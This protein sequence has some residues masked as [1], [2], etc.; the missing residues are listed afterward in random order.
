MRVSR[1]RTLAPWRAGSL[2]L[3]VCLLLL[4]GALA[5]NVPHPPSA[6]Q[7][8]APRL[9]LPATTGDP[10]EGL[11]SPGMD[12]FQ[13]VS[14]RL[15]SPSCL[16][17]GG[18]HGWLAYDHADRAVWAA[19]EPNC[20]VVVSNGSLVDGIPVGA[21]PFGVA[22]DP[23][24]DLVFV[25]N[26]GSDNVSVI[27]D[28]TDQP[29]ASIGVGVAPAGIAYAGAIG[30]MFVANS[31][32]NNISII[33][34]ATMSVVG[35]VNVGMGPVGVA[36]DALDG[37]VYV[38]NN[39]SSSVSVIAE[40][41][42]TV[43]AT[44]PAGSTPRGVAWDSGD[45]RIFV[46]NQGSNNVT[47]INAAAGT[48]LAAVPAIPPAYGG[49]TLL[50]GMTYDN[51]SGAIWIGAGWAYAMEINASAPQ[52]V[53]F[54]AVDPS[55]M[56][57]DYDAHQVCG[58]D[59]GNVSLEC[60]QHASVQ[61]TQPLWFNETGLLPGTPW[62][63]VIHAYAGDYPVSGTGPSLA[64]ATMKSALSQYTFTIPPAGGYSA[65]PS[66]GNV[67]VTSPPTT[68]VVTFGPGPPLYG[69]TFASQGLP[70]GDAWSVDLDG[71]LQISTRSTLTFAEPN[72]SY[73][74]AVSGP[75]GLHVQPA[76]G[77]V[78]VNGSAVL[79]NVTFS[80]PSYFAVQFS[81]VG[82]PAGTAWT[83]IV[84][85]TWWF[86]TSST[87]T[88]NLTVGNHSFSA[89]P[90]LGEYLAGPSSGTF[91]V[92]A[93]DA[94]LIINLTYVR[95]YV[96]IFTESGL[97]FGALWSVTLSDG[98]SYNTTAG[99]LNV[100]EPNGTY[101]FAPQGPAGSTPVFVTGSFVIAGG[102]VAVSVPF[103][104]GPAPLTATIVYSIE[105]VTCG[106][107]GSVTNQVL[108]VANITGGQAP[109][110]AF[111]SFPGGNATGLSVLV[112]VTWPA[113]IQTPVVVY[114]ADSAGATVQSSTFLAMELPPCPPPYQP[115]LPASPPPAESPAWPLLA[116][117]AAALLPGAIVL[118]IGVRRSR[119]PPADG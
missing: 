24:R 2:G 83:V 53:G 82:L 48:E 29:V 105:G 103:L 62:S 64:F 116:G 31:G 10:F 109:Y 68:V 88:L 16:T 5:A 99:W 110:F 6:T 91:F 70:S 111:W 50:D 67:T 28:L 26:T 96:A 97:P 45:D 1:P 113:A 75:Q 34:D 23:A 119:K 36:V 3:M 13:L 43:V 46:S 115:I 59:T 63:V 117:L 58:S 8:I 100:S 65:N 69:V 71:Y 74:Y 94:G 37:R 80:G 21:H 104:V 90:V 47:V 49:P 18:S 35:N 15:A 44:L 60:F 33:D 54:L 4:V 12:H 78:L 22:V 106:S 72:G 79:V 9:S 57:Y 73:A 32:S 107:D 17:Y 41:N 86:S 39:A 108:L 11:S 7:P 89:P 38:A 61:A 52:V 95:T 85:G 66:T 40:S 19:T 14:T 112:T 76:S 25:A 118:W 93:P 87:L 77:N 55:G 56:A 27:S 84:D 92:W 30:A 42:R 101:T 20:V 98:T 81:A 51:V 102:P 114:V